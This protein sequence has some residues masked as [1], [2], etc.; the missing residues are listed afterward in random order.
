MGAT[1]AVPCRPIG[2]SSPK[3]RRSSPRDSSSLDLHRR[4]HTGGKTRG[5]FARRLMA[6]GALARGNRFMMRPGLRSGDV[7][8]TRPPVVEGRPENAAGADA[9]QRRHLMQEPLP[10][11]RSR[12][13]IHGVTSLHHHRRVVPLRGV[14]L[15]VV[16]NES[17]AP[18]SI[19]SALARPPGVPPC[20][21]SPPLEAQHHHALDVVRIASHPRHPIPPRVEEG[22]ACGQRH[23]GEPASVLAEH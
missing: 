4:P 16:L 12:E 3:L 20:H 18:L 21:R 23:L 22:E 2:A 11:R 8:P 9:G 10:I 5:R 6:E 7:C 14:N 15:K 1:E 19:R 13:S 17:N